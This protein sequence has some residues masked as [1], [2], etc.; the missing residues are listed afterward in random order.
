MKKK[1][2]LV[3]LLVS[4]ILSGSIATVASAEDSYYLPEYGTLAEH[5]EWTTKA[6]TVDKVAELGFRGAGVKV[7]VLDSGIAL[8]T[9]GINTKLVAYKD[10]LPSQPPLPDHGTQ[11]A[12]VISSQYDLSLIHI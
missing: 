1:F 3:A 10:F 7:A 12:S 4:G 2:F 6:I 11:T 8:N 5:N 9:P